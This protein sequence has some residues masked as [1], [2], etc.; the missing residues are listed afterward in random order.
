MKVVIIGAGLAGLAAADAL[1]AA[2]R[3]VEIFEANPYWGGRAHSIC[4][5]GFVFDEGPHV[6]F[7]QDRSV[8]DVFSHGEPAM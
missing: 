1:A 3:E 8:Q 5:D 4:I 6:S 7:T 2:G